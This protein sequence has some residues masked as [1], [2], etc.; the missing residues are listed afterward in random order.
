MKAYLD[1]LQKVR[2]EG[3]PRTDRT[4]VGTLSLFGH[5]L[6][7]DLREGFPLLTTKKVFFRGIVYELLWFLRGE[8]NVRW[9]QAHNVHIWDPWADPDGEL[10]PIYGYQWRRWPTHD[11]GFIDQIRQVIDTL[12]TNPSSRR[13]VVSAWNPAQLDQMRLPPCHILFQFYSHDGELSCQLY[14]RSAD[15]FI[16]VPFNIASYAL[17]T[18]M[19][20]QVTGHRVGE[21]IHTFGDVHIYQNHLDAVDTQL[22]RTPRPLPR[23]ELNPDVTDI[24]D[25][26]YDDIRLV[27]YHPHPPIKAP[28][29]V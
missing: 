3:K 1:L 19:I 26:T 18:H 16:G 27:G 7:I 28:V 17:L 22:Q 29:A 25:F 24:D 4:G 23:L 20:A 21:F 5:Q 2:T 6:R 11:G 9:L 13:I 15:L 10:G 12:R 14:Q 8:T